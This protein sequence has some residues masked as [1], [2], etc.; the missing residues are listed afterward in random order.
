[1]LTDPA[2]RNVIRFCQSTWP[3]INDLPSDVRLYALS[4]DHLTYGNGILMFDKR[5]VAP[6]ALRPFILDALHA[7]HQEIVKSRAKTRQTVWWPK[8]G[9]CIEQHIGACATCA[10]WRQPIVESLLSL[11]LPNYPWQKV[12]TDLFEHNGKHYITVVDF[13]RIISNLLS[14]VRRQQLM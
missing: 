14:C 2:L 8:I 3:S 7:A 6:S 1:M 5:V 4:K 12:A 9:A 13:Y 11:K 10:H